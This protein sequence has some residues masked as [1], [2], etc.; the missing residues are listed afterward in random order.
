MH[1]LI[2]AVSRFTQLTGICR[3]AI[4]HAKAVCDLPEMRATLLIGA[5]QEAYFRAGLNSAS[6]NLAVADCRNTSW[7]R[8]RWYSRTLPQLASRMHADLVHLGYPVPVRRS[9]FAMP[10]VAT[11]HDLYPYDQPGNFGFPNVVF[12]RIFLRQCVREADALACVSEFTRQ[13]LMQYFP[14]VKQDG[15]IVISSYSELPKIVPEQP[16]ALNNTRFLLTVGQHRANKNIDLIIRAFELLA[17]S[18]S[19]AR[20][21]QLVVAGANGPETSA[22]KSL[23]H[24]FALEERVTF[25]DLL[26]DANLAWLYRSC[27]LF[28]A[29]SSVE[30]FCLPLL[31]A[32]ELSPRILC[33]DIAVFREVA[34][35]SA[36]YFDLGAEALAAA[37]ANGLGSPP[38]GHGSRESRFT[39]VAATR[40]YAQFYSRLLGLCDYSTDKYIAAD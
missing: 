35:S 7:S 11:V 38:R 21:V 19:I 27:E 25:L 26:S 1:V 5:W 17:R 12:N 9:R 13:R 2:P 18:E 40:A 33:S 22:L 6:V 39:R 24:R 28:I 14:E 37:I 15:T 32:R 31:E 20:D 23:V 8:N 16:S 4:N 3:H 34:G 36:E 10:I 30:G 29:A